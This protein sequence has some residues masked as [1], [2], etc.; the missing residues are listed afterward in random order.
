MHQPVCCCLFNYFETGMYCPHYRPHSLVT[1]ALLEEWLIGIFFKTR[2]HDSCFCRWAFVF[3][4]SVHLC[5][6]KGPLSHSQDT[7]QVK[8]QSSLHVGVGRG[9]HLRMAIPRVAG[10]HCVTAPCSR[11]DS[12]FTV[13]RFRMSLPMVNKDVLLPKSCRNLF[14]S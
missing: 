3:F 7:D 8:Q 10:V 4:P 9:L 1:R 12:P 2:T 13:Q 11:A 6:L 5:I 14:I